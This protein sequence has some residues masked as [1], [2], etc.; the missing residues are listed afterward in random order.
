M[1]L[2]SFPW[3]CACFRSSWRVGSAKAT[4][5]EWKKK[6]EKNRR[7]FLEPNTARVS[8]HGPCCKKTFFPYK[9]QGADTA[10][11]VAWHGPCQQ[12]WRKTK[13]INNWRANTAARVA[14]HDPCWQVRWSFRFLVFTHVSD[15]GGHFWLFGLA[16]MCTVLFRPKKRREGEDEE[17]KSNQG[18]WRTEIIKRG[19]NWRSKLSNLL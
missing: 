12:V 15:P 14:W 18:F 16:V 13:K 8:W 2:M 1:R 10:G 17:K 7:K 11:R 9:N 3:Y 4:V 6:K 5:E 19:S